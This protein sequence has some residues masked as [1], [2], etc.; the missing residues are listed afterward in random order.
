MPQRVLMHRIVIGAN[1]LVDRRA[2]GR[3]A[4]RRS[5]QN[6]HRSAADGLLYTAACVR[7]SQTTIGRRR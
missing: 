4:M 5:V 2:A 1:K 3:A 6:R 7:S